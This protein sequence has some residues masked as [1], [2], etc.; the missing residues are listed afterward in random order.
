SVSEA[1]I[2][3]QVKG[4]AVTSA[5]RFPLLPD[6]PSVS[7]SVPGY[8][9]SSWG[10]IFAPTKTPTEI[11]RKIHSDTVSAL[12]DV[13]LQQRLEQVGAVFPPSSPNKREILW[14]NEIGKWGKVTREENIKPE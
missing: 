7:D 1:I 4:V 12:A 6:L 5:K 14:A 11:V 9:V 10:A 3:G 8:D 13:S 2:S